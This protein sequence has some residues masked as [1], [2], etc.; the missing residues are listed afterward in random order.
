[1]NNTKVGCGHLNHIGSFFHASGWRLGDYG[2]D[3]YSLRSRGDIRSRSYIPESS[4]V[5]WALLD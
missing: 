3:K 4:L 1:M 5:S 2:L